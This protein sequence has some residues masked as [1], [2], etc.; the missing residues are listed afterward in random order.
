MNSDLPGELGPLDPGLDQLMQTLTSAPST[1]ELAGEQ[2][3]LAIFRANAGTAHANGR[4]TVPFDGTAPMHATMPIRTGGNGNGP[5][6]APSRLFKGPSRWGLR[7]AAA[8]T[9]LAVGGTAAAAY[10][11]I[12]PNPIQH[13]AYK[14][15]GFAGVPDA[16]QNHPGLSPSVTSHAGSRPGHR[17]SAPTNTPAPGTS[18]GLHH[19]P[20]P[21]QSSPAAAGHEQLSASATGT[22]ITAGTSVTID[23]HLTRSGSS[24]AG[25]SVKLLERVANRHFW[26]IAGV[27]QTNS[28][29]NVAVTVSLLKTNAAFVFVAPGGVRSPVVTVLVSPPITATLTPGPG[30]LKD[31]LSVSTHYARP[32]NVVVL[33]VQAASGA[34]VKIKA[35]L[36]NAHGNT[37]FV[38]RARV[39]KNKELRAVLKATRRHASSV[40][41]TVSVPAPS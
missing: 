35:R 19:S 11:A 28:S 38:I 17:K 32:G 12:L 10:A 34:W 40:S 33:Q 16:Q 15:F 36:L 23:G 9:V 29:G 22:E 41:N 31:L 39:L 24:V 18:S 6:V 3:V 7:I 13:L 14:A 5:P 27:Q 20:S 1:G 21:R 2:T 37:T 4:G 30:G 25:T 8:A 26:R